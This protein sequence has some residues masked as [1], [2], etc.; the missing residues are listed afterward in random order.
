MRTSIKLFL[1][2]AALCACSVVDDGTAH[3]ANGPEDLSHDMIVLGERLDD[4]YSVSN[5][6]SAL[7]SLYPSKAGRVDLKP[8]DI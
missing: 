5:V 3:R 1:P 4:P 7:L 2:V 8:T 6:E